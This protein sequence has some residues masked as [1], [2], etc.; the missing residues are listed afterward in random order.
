[1]DVRKIVEQQLGGSILALIEAQAEIERLKAELKAAR[2]A[3]K[4]APAAG[5][6]GGDQEGVS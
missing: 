3:A 4:P 5:Y 2:E 1:M 6:E